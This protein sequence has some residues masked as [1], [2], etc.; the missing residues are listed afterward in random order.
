MMSF[1]RPGFQVANRKDKA[2]DQVMVERKNRASFTCPKCYVKHLSAALA[3]LECARGAMNYIIASTPFPERRTNLLSL[4][5]YVITT[6]GEEKKLLPSLLDALTS[7]KTSLARA[8]ILLDE[9]QNYQS[10]EFMAVGHLIDAEETINICASMMHRDGNIDLCNDLLN[11]SCVIRAGRI[12]TQELAS[13]QDADIFS[14]IDSIDHRIYIASE[15]AG[16]LTDYLTSDQA[17]IDWYYNFVFARAHLMEAAR[18]MPEPDNSSRHSTFVSELFR[19]DSFPF[20]G[21]SLLTDYP[22]AQFAASDMR[23]TLEL[24]YETIVSELEIF[25]RNTNAID[26]D[27]AEVINDS[28]SEKEGGDETMACKTAKKGK[29]KGGKKGCK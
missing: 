26:F 25:T 23:F 24:L 17:T 15:D 27:N 22:N 20:T 16:P 18:E 7:A 29:C 11:L 5:H 13:M 28:P 1:L 4:L 14:L 9:A 3:H 2:M 10:H 6:E 8:S 12:K 21:K 19:M